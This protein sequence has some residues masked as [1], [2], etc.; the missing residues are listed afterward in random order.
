MC[1]QVTKR[2]TTYFPF[3]ILSILRN[4]RTLSIDM[5]E[6]EYRETNVQLKL[7]VRTKWE[8]QAQSQRR[9]FTRGL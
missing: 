5:T 2:K 7:R 6:S 1:E 8:W 3:S 9:R 4:N